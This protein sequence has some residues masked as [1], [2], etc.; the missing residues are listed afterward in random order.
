MTDHPLA[1]AADGA[2]LST[3]NPDGSR[4]WLYPRVSPGRFLTARRLVGWALIALFTALPYVRIGGKPS[5]LLD[6]PAREFTLFGTTFLPTDT[7]VLALFLLAAFLAIFLLTALLGRVWCGWGCPQTVYLELVYRPLERLFE[8]RHYATDGRAPVST[9]ARLAKLAAYTIVSLV[10]AHT[11]LAYF[12][13]TD[14]LFDWMRRSPVEHPTAFLVMAATTGLMLFDFAWFRE[15]LCTLIC[16]YGRF[17]SVLLDRQSLIIGYDA[18]RGEPRARLGRGRQAA[19]DA[20]DCIDCGLCV[21]TCPT[22]IDIRQGLQME[23]VGCAHCIDACDAVMDRIG[24]PRGLIRYA[25]RQALD[26]GRTRLLRPRVVIYPVLIGIAVVALG[27][28][29]G[30]QD[31]ADVSVLRVRTRPYRV[32]DSGAVENVV[33]L[34]IVNRSGATRA[35]DVRAPEP[36]AL[37]SAD[38]PLTLPAGGTATATLHVVLPRS[39]FG[40]GRADVE[41]RV[42]ADAGLDR[43]I[44]HRLLGPLFGGAP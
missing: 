40:G 9:G 10:L 44:R 36:A 27:L 38:L 12:V 25:S 33:L 37:A 43:S 4:R 28:T 18:R 19:D 13:G 2:V 29:L 7:L 17:Q 20:G 15:Q 22:G 39:S 14:R 35:Y 26:E 32:L 30:G 6:L 1:P 8:R 21:A 34:K 3:L 24:R 42:T 23:C 31:T 16:P 41:L 11:F 5:I